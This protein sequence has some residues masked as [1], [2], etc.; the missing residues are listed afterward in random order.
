MPFPQGLQE[1]KGKREKVIPYIFSFAVGLRRKGRHLEKRAFG[2]HSYIDRDLERGKKEKREGPLPTS[3]P[4]K[5]G[6]EEKGEGK[7]RKKGG[8]VRLPKKK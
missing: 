5:G 1:E 4:R 8:G 6:E 2:L 7:F 3:L